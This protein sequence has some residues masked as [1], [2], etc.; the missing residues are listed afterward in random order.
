MDNIAYVG[1]DCSSKAIH[2]VWIDE[3]ENIILQEA[4]NVL[5]LNGIEEFVPA[6]SIIELAIGR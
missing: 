6:R 4:V 2:G 3:D 1:F 5:G